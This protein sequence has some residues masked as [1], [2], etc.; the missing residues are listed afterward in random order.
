MSIRRL[1]VF[2]D[3]LPPPM[4]TAGAAQS[5]MMPFCVPA[6]SLGGH[7]DRDQRPVLNPAAEN[8]IASGARRGCAVL[9]ASRVADFFTEQLLVALWVI[10]AHRV[11]IER[12]GG[13]AEVVGSHLP[14]LAADRKGSV[15]AGHHAGGGDVRAAAQHDRALRAPRH[16]V[17]MCVIRQAYARRADG[18]VSGG[19][20][21][22]AAAS[23]YARSRRG[24]CGG[25][26]HQRGAHEP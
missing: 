16:S 23:R 7:I 18:D 20:V 26:Q 6:G 10:G 1:V 17:L 3:W 2:D 25:G 5:S 24:G 9:V 4:T 11:D 14:G 8:H 13:P 12:R 19:R 22:G 21:G 15:D